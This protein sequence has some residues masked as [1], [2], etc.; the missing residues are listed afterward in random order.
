[1]ALL[2]LN[3]DTIEFTHLQIHSNESLPSC[4]TRERN[5]T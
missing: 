4:N 3:K 5:R 1:M 2:L